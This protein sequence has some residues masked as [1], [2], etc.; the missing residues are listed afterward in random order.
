MAAAVVASRKRSSRWG[1]SPQMNDM[2]VRVASR[3]SS[4]KGDKSTPVR[5]RMVGGYGRVGGKSPWQM[6]LN[7]DLCTCPTSRKWVPTGREQPK[8]PLLSHQV[9]PCAGS[10]IE[11]FDGEPVGEGEGQQPCQPTPC[12]VGLDHVV[13]HKLAQ[14]F[15]LGQNGGA[16][17]LGEAAGFVVYRAGGMGGRGIVFSQFA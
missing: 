5:W 7:W 16:E 10:Q 12:L 17:E 4:T 3:P 14:G 8:V 1:W 11:Q 6:V 13:V 9:Q 2:R 15:A